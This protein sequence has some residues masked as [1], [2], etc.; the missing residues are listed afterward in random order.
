[1]PF[2]STVS[3]DGEYNIKL[4]DSDQYVEYEPS[5]G[6]WIKLASPNPDSDKQKVLYRLF[7]IHMFD[8]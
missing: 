8:C 2:Q 7:D 4:L 3:S 6:T 1:M 5:K